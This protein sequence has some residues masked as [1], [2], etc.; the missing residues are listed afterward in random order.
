MEREKLLRIDPKGRQTEK[1]PQGKILYSIFTLGVQPE[2]VPKAFFRCGAL[3]VSLS[4]F[5]VCT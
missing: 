2:Y 1:I 5:G 4:S 3:F